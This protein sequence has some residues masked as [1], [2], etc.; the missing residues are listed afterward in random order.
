MPDKKQSYRKKAR[1]S[2]GWALTFDD[3]LLRPAKTEFHP[4]D[5]DISTKLGPFTLSTPIIS[6][7]M[8]TVTE[9]EMAI[10]MAL[11]GGLGVIHRNCSLEQQLQMVM[12]VKRARSFI[13]D[14]VATILPNQTIGEAIAE[15]GRLGIS[16]MPV[17]DDDHKI[18]GII[19]RRDIP[20]D[21]NPSG[22]VKDVMTPN[23]VC[24]HAGVSREEALHKLWEIRKEKL[25]I[26]DQNGKLVGL[27]TKKDLKPEFPNASTDPRGRLVC[28]L[29]VSPFP[30]KSQV[31]RDT[32]KKI[33]EYVDIFFTD[34]AEFFKV[35]DMEGTRDLM[36]WL[37]SYFVVGN[38]G[39]YEAAE[40][41]LTEAGFP[42]DQ[43]IGIKV[44]MGS[45]SICT[46]SMQT[47]VGAPTFMA[48]AEVAD[49]I[50][51]YNPRVALIA[52]GGFKHPGDLPKAFAVGA[53]VI[54]TGH[55][56]AGCTESP[57]L[58]D[59][60][61]GR[62]VKVYRGMGSEEARRVGTFVHDRYNKE[63]RIAEGVSDHVPFVGPVKG[64][65]Q[66]LTD[67]LKSGMIYCGAR[68]IGQMRKAEFRQ[69][70]YAGKVESGPHDLLGR[71][72]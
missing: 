28:G 67:G 4:V 29:G 13:I 23:P 56:F 18:I 2:E 20:F 34:V 5:V 10:Q 52:D 7:A 44:G 46:T 9:T 1:A 58:L 37:D 55:F 69:V 30:P 17:I 32:L 63:H 21:E 15:M 42:E 70:T 36:E 71:G 35:E 8:D 16:G 27:I 3:V 65:L 53:D 49:A 24:M 64:V 50:A 60:I 41:L 43:L 19:T 54:M 33:D 57:G 31:D 68:T 39:T 6:A 11:L 48:T 22:L 62:K 59:T 47:G 66:Q 12:R 26:V 14:N 72:I 40:Y 45:G 25:P 38:I 61:G 51:D